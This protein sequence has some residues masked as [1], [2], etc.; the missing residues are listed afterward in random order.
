MTVSASITNIAGAARPET[1]A[2]L[3]RDAR[4]SRA[5]DFI[6]SSQARFTSELIRICE[7]PA[8]P[9]KEAER[10]RYVAARFAELD[11]TETHIDS[12]GNVIGFYRGESE[13]PTL[14][15][16]AHLDTVFPEGTDVGVR[17]RSSRLLA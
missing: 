10:G 9:F 12:A 1:V 15:L 16:S 17:R 7:I 14:A 6:D 5:F 11:L 8:P 2:E 13:E 3:L 4:I